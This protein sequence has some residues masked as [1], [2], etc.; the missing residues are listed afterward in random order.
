[1][2][3]ENKRFARVRV[4]ETVISR[5]EEGMRRWGTPVPES[6]ELEKLRTATES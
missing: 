3:A 1:M 4:L 5:I 6:A 2:A